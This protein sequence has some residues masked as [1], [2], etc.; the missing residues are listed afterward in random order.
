MWTI[1]SGKRDF[2]DEEIFATQGDYGEIQC[3]RG[4]HDKVYD[5]VGLFLE[6]DQAREECM[7]PSSMVPKCPVCGGNMAMH[8]RC[9]QYFVEE[10]HW[11]EAASRYADFLKEHRKE[12]VVLLELGVGFNTPVFCSLRTRKKSRKITVKRQITE[13]S[14]INSTEEYEERRCA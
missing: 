11:H 5:A 14:H 10:E 3:A 8:L 2:A 6:M 1:S 7:I 9:D 12:H 4:C 13:G